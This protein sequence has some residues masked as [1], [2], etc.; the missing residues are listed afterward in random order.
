[1]YLDM[2]RLLDRE[3][4]DV[5]LVGHNHIYQRWAP[6]H[7]NGTRAASGIRQFTVG[8]GGRSLY[9]L[10]KKPRPAN[11]LAVQNKSFGVLQMTLHD[12]SYDY[13]GSGCPPIRFSGTAGRSPA[14]KDRATSPA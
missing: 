2:W 6:Q 5:M 3:G 1:M 11:L 9:S 12:D 13:S 14:D 10:G 4:V 8:T 7:A